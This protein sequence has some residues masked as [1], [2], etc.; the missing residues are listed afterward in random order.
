MTTLTPHTAALPQALVDR[1]VEALG[2]DAVILEREEVDQYRDPYWV[3]GDDTYFGVAVVCPASTEEVQTVVRLANEFDVP[4]WTHS[5]G[6]NNGY[7]GPSPRVGGSIQVS[8][9]RMNKVLE[10]NERLAYAVVEPGVRWFDLQE[11]L[12]AGG[13]KLMLSV[14]DLGWGSVIGNSMDN[15]VTYLPLG[16][17]FMAPT[18]ME[19]VL[20]DGDL[21]RTGMG[22]VPDNKSW[23]LYKRSLGPSLDA[24][25]THSSLGIVVRMG[26]WLQPMPEA[27]QTLVLTVEKDAQLE[28]AI[29]T[30]SG[31]MLDGTVRG[32]PCFYPAPSHVTVLADEMMPIR[33]WNEESIEEFGRECGFGRWA[34]RVALW[35]DRNVLDLKAAKIEKVWTQIPG[36]TVRKG[37]VYTPEEF[38]QIENGT[39]KVQA[40]IPTLQLME[41]IP[42]FIGHVGFSPVVPLVGSEIRHV[43]TQMETRAFAMGRAP[44]IG[45]LCIN[46]RSAAVVASFFFDRGDATQGREVFDVVKELVKDLGAQGYGEYRAHLDF[47]DVAADQFSFNDGAY[48]RFVQKIKDAVD[49]KGVISPGRHGIWPA[50]YRSPEGLDPS[51][52]DHAAPV[53]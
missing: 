17:D 8:L 42:D 27:Y 16:A 26:V 6:R 38:D 9:R 19:V 20:P 24:L 13:H 43:M 18:G 12:R 21:L 7:G 2:E 15:G 29:D 41:Q 48:R 50:R 40:G 3:A 51:A 30:L 32:V 10:I 4:I 46:G 36:A 34:V 49:P 52:L 39:E 47:M 5:Q 37:R 45:I 53:S 35:E 44:G 1:L 28:A 23:H 25:F 14:P 22:A 11:A 31:L 33:E